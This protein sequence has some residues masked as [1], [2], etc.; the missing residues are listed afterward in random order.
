[1]AIFQFPLQINCGL[2]PFGTGVHKLHQLPVSASNFSKIRRRTAE[3]RMAGKKSKIT[4][5]KY[6]TTEQNRS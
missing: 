1:M 3:I 6:N 5:I 2:D 4:G